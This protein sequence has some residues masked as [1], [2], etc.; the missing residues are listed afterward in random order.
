MHN[1]VHMFFI[2]GIHMKDIKKCFTMIGNQISMLSEDEIDFIFR[3]ICIDLK[4]SL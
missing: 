4:W 3:G 1:G 2:S